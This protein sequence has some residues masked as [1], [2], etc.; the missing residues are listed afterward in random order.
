[1]A[2]GSYEQ[3]VSW[4]DACAGD[5][6]SDA[7]VY[8]QFGMGYLYQ[9][10]IK[11]AEEQFKQALQMDKN[12]NT[13]IGGSYKQIGIDKLNKGRTR[14]AGVFLGKA[15]GYQQDLR[16]SIVQT[17]F[18]KGAKTLKKAYFDLA[19]TLDADYQIK[20]FNFLMARANKASDEACIDLYQLAIA[21][22][23]DTCDL[24]KTAGKRLARLTDNIEK[25]NPLDAKITKYE[26]LAGKFVDT[27]PDYKLYEPGI[28]PFKLA[29]GA[30][31]KWIRCKGQGAT[32]YEFRSD[33]QK[34][35]V[36]LRNGKVYRA[37][38]GDSFPATV[39]S[40]I[41]IKALEP[42]VIFLTLRR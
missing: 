15:I 1:M 31:T 5:G 17:C 33:N 30:L 23:G 13:A 39:S 32:T 7:E 35:E 34:Y 42:T 18:E 4:L 8:F 26:N 28:Y 40:D 37:W 36:Y 3:A 9:A 21:Y 2:A 38:A 16:Q 14:E 24:I 12:Y 19:V 25:R 10:K 27:P 6:A 22:C 41:K 29:K 11:Q 20:V